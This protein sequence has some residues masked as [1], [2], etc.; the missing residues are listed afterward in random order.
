[1][2]VPRL[3]RLV[4]VDLPL[5]PAALA[6]APLDPV[7]PASQLEVELDGELRR[8]RVD[9][10][11]GPLRAAPVPAEE[12]ERDGVEDRRLAAAVAAG[13]GPEVAAVE[14]DDLLVA[15]AEETLHGDPERDH[16]RTSPI[17]SSASASTA[18]ACSWPSSRARR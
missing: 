1:M 2:L 11:L 3:V 9:Q 12:G 17:N 10:V 15:V 18:S 14:V 7:A 5:R 16:G 8:V 13:E 4:A 6:E